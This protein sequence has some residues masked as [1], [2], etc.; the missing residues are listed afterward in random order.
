MKSRQRLKKL[1]KE[2]VKTAKKQKENNKK[3]N[4]K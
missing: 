4:G 2:K 1:H 3:I